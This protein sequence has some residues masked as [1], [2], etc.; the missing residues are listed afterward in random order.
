ML[1]LYED[2]W[3]TKLA[4]PFGGVHTHAYF[5]ECDEGNVLFYNTNHNDDEHIISLSSVVDVKFFERTT[6]FSNIE[7]I[8]T[9]GHTDGSM[10]FMYRSPYGLRY[11]FTGDTLFRS[12]VGWGTLVFPSAG[13]NVEA[14]NES[15]MIYLDLDPDVVI[16]SAYSGDTPVTEVTHDQ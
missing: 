3:Q 15:L 14:L 2:L 8:P 10:S 7:V 1:K 4:I 6:H 16:S 13:G 11:L 5:L 12:N 9:P